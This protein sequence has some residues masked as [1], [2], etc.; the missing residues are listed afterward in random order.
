MSMQDAFRLYVNGDVAMYWDGSWAVPQLLNN[1]D[2]KFKWATFSMPTI[3]KEY[4]Q[5]AD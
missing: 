5:F 2:V 1:T 4:S 3:D